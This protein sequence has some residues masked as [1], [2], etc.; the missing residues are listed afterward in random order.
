MGYLNNQ[1]GYR[2]EMLETRSVVKR[3]NWVLLDPDG[4]V[5]NRIPGYEN[6]DLTILGSP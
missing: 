3:N 1:L 5:K 6:C 2:D 4:L